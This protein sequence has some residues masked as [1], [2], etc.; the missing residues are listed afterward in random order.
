M[1]WVTIIWSMVASA[2]LTLAAVH[3]LVWWRQREALSN[4]LFSL[5][6]AATAVQAG[7][8]LWAIVA[9]TPAEFG[10]ALWWA[11]LPFWLVIVS[12]VGF[13]RL[14]LRAGR[15]WLAGTVC[16][17]RTLALILNCFFSPNI[18]Y[19]EITSLRHI[20]FLGAS[21]SVPEGIPNPWMLVGQLGSLLFIIFVADATLAVWRRGGRQQAVALASVLSF[22]IHVYQPG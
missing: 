16:G 13:V 1:N 15:P 9:K 12:L 11:H 5:T 18:N 3:G 7:T 10:R 14:Y 4:L 21:V 19:R 22:R 8:E 6:A 20:Q 2:C 17:L